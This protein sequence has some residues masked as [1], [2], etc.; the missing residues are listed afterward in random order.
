MKYT[1]SMT[2]LMIKSVNE[3][4]RLN[5]SI[6]DLKSKEKSYYKPT[7]DSLMKDLVTKREN[8][9][10]ETTQKS[11][12]YLEWYKKDLHKAYVIDPARITPDSEL[13][14]GNFDLSASELE[15]M[16][17]NHS[18]NRTMQRMIWDYAN[19]SGIKLNRKGMESEADVMD[20]AN[21]VR[22]AVISAMERPE[23]SDIWTSS[24]YL[25]QLTHGIPEFD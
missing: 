24:D 2:D 15:E 17:D 16:L 19:K 8:L 6:K 12:S 20:K 7:Y 5:A 25:A 22:L 23:Y 13:L 14:K 18:N 11:D 10:S 1:T 9:I 21:R 3:L 4:K